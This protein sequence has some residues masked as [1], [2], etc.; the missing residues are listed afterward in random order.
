MTQKEAFTNKSVFPNEISA[1]QEKDSFLLSHLL[2]G[3]SS[4]GFQGGTGQKPVLGQPKRTP[5]LKKLLFG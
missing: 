3:F 2:K 4:G 1:K 5:H